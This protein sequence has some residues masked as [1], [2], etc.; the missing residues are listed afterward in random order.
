MQSLTHN[1]IHASPLRPPVGLK[2]VLGHS[3][4]HGEG[5]IKA[6]EP[7]EVGS[8]GHS[9]SLSDHIWQQAFR[10]WGGQ[11]FCLCLQCPDTLDARDT[12]VLNP[13]RE[14]FAKKEC[15][16]LLSEVFETCHPVVS[17]PQPRPLLTPPFLGSLL[18]SDPNP[19]H[20]SGETPQA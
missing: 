2:R 13:L 16:I 14:P 11:Q 17:G 15:S 4:S 7:Q 20:A 5:I 19:H 12:C 6:H 8:G 18:L 9:K 1:H 3:P 10:G